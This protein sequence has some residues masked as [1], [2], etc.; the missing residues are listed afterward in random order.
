MR[1]FDFNKSHDTTECEQLFHN[2][3]NVDALHICLQGLE[4]YHLDNFTV[5]TNAVS[6]SGQPQLKPEQA[7]PMSL[8]RGG[9]KELSLSS[10]GMHALEPNAFLDSLSGLETLEIEETAIFLEHART[11]ETSKNVGGTNVLG[12]GSLS[13][14]HH[15]ATLRTLKIR[16]SNFHR[17]PAHR[18]CFGENTV[19]VPVVDLLV[20]PFEILQSLVRLELRDLPTGDSLMS[21]ALLKNVRF[22]TLS[23]MGM[24]EVEL[25]LFLQEMRQ[26]RSLEL[27]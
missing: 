4:A 25:A 21:L 6:W 26:L 18:I 16:R 13:L 24:D 2:Y 22:L 12:P 14:Q 27:S 3:P 8:M 5:A 11:H 10:G 20:I 9:I 17:Y 23:D 7:Y 1:V 15:A 19:I